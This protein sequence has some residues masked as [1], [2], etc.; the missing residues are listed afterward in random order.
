MFN[1]T[2]FCTIAWHGTVLGSKDITLPFAKNI[3]EPKPNK[4][5]TENLYLKFGA[6]FVNR[7]EK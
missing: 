5:H 4:T 6:S 7:E 3:A 2:D 1:E